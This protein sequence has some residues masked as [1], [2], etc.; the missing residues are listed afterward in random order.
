MIMYRLCK[1]MGLRGLSKFFALRE[2]DKME[3]NR[4][5]LER[6][7]RSHDISRS[8]IIHGKVVVRKDNKN[9]IFT[10]VEQGY[11]LF[12]LSYSNGFTEKMV[13][14]HSLNKNDMVNKLNE[15]NYKVAR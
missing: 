15:N 4:A 7:L 9:K 6:E 13:L 8:D 5:I 11:G 10:I 12:N 14:A 2:F 1:I 3:R